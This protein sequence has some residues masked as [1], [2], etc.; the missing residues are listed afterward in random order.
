MG[1]SKKKG[2]KEKKAQSKKQ[3]QQ[4]PQRRSPSPNPKS[5][6]SQDQ[7]TWIAMRQASP[8]R[9][10]PTRYGKYDDDGNDDDGGIVPSCSRSAEGRDEVDDDGNGDGN[11]AQSL[12]ADSDNAIFMSSE[13]VEHTRKEREPSFSPRDANAVEGYFKVRFE[14]DVC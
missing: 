13:E 1:S 2:G 9:P 6:L 10:S 8:T 12:S 7:A 3:Q 5:I 14:N 4:P 11:I